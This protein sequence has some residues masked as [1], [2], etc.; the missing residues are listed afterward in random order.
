MEI[1]KIKDETYFADLTLIAKTEKSLIFRDK[2]QNIIKIMNPLYLAIVEA[3]GNDISGRILLDK[4]LSSVPEINKP[5]AMYVDL[6]DKFM[7]YR[8]KEAKGVSLRRH[9]KNKKYSELLDLRQYIL[10]Y[11]KI[12]DVVKRGNKIG[13]VFPDLANL[14][15]IYIDSEGNITFID[16]DGIQIDDYLTDSFSASLGNPIAYLNTKYMHMGKN[17]F[18]EELDKKSLICIFFKLVFN[19]NI[20]GIDKNNLILL[21]ELL[22]FINLHDDEIKQKIWNIFNESVCNEFIGE[23]LYRLID[24]YKLKMTSLNG[25]KCKMLVRL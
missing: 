4:D 11:N 16:F 3:L 12:E 1:I 22:N 18:T 14:D 6:Y 24:S 2:K 10:D 23:D 21:E 25:C 17:I 7:G 19:A 13:L 5:N 9:E 20:S 15:N 8:S